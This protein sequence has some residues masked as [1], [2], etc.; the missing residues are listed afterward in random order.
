MK[1]ILLAS[2][3]VIQACVYSDAKTMIKNERQEAKACQQYEA[4]SRDKVR[5]EA[6]LQTKPL[7]EL[8]QSDQARYLDIQSRYT[9][10]KQS[11]AQARS[12][13]SRSQHNLKS[14]T[15]A[16]IGDNQSPR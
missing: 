6:E 12:N 3:L 9:E 8:S 7:L 16:W 10:V 5:I 4:M 13:L 11:C 15:E 14:S 2:I 1:Y